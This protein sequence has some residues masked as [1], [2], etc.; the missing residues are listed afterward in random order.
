MSAEGLAALNAANP[1][2]EIK[3]PVTTMAAGGIAQ[4]KK[5][6]VS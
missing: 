6:S 3:D 5:R 2:Q 1:A 4:L